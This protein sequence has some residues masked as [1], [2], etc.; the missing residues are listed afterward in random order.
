MAALVD[1]AS[2]GEVNTPAL[3]A[4]NNVVVVSGHRMSR[5]RKR[6]DQVEI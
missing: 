4:P 1:H 3:D 2:V 5:R 6:P